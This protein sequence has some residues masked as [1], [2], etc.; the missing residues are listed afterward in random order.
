MLNWR[1]INV[2]YSGT[3][4]NEAS[5]TFLRQH[6]SIYPE[7]LGWITKNLWLLSLCDGNIWSND[8]DCSFQI[9]INRQFLIFFPEGGNRPS[10][11][12]SVFCSVY[13]TMDKCRNQ[14]TPNTALAVLS[15]LCV[16]LTDRLCYSV[17]CDISWQQA[18]PAITGRFVG[19]TWT[20]GSKWCN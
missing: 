15:P 8:W 5:F 20:D 1:V 7:E 3:M 4:Y 10:F 12:S 16:Q 2:W 13:G 9:H 6:P 17:D 14:V 19:R 11:R 18:T